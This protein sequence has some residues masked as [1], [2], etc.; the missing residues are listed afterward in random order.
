MTDQELS[1]WREPAAASMIAEA[2]AA[3]EE[4][5]RE[6]RLLRATMPYGVMFEPNTFYFGPDTPDETSWEIAGEWAYRED[7]TVAIT[8]ISIFPSRTIV[9]RDGSRRRRAAGSVPGRGLDREHLRKVGVGSVRREIERQLKI[10]ARRLA[11]ADAQGVKLGPWAFKMIAA[12]ERASERPGRKRS[13]KPA[14]WW[15]ERADE[16]L[17]A[18]EEVGSRY[19]AQ[20]HLEESEVWKVSTAG[21]RWRVR[22]LHEMGLIEDAGSKPR[23]GPNHPASNQDASTRPSGS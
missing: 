18:A 9:D 6:F 23:R 4:S 19:G 3:I 15:V 5:E 2:N 16:Y 17:A 11:E 14:A 10:Q 1:D 8:S 7:D 13:G 12:G 22:R 21:I 20:A